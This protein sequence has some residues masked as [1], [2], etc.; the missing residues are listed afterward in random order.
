MTKVKLSKNEINDQEYFI[1]FDDEN[2]IDPDYALISMEEKDE[3]VKEFINDK[4]ERKSPEKENIDKGVIE[5]GINDSK[6][7][8]GVKNGA[9]PKFLWSRL[10]HE[11]LSSEIRIG[12]LVTKM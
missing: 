9:I 10:E 11:P 12:D 7:N 3:Y 6:Y 1:N 5:N 4:K 2:E 8:N